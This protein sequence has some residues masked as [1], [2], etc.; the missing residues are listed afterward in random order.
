MLSLFIFY[1]F[2]LITVKAEEEP[3]PKWACLNSKRCDL[4]DANCSANFVGN[5]HTARLTVNDNPALR[6]A[7]SRP[8][9]ILECFN[10]DGSQVCTTGDSARDLNFKLCTVD[11][12]TS[13]CKEDNKT[14]LV[15]RYEYEFQNL[16]DGNGQTVQMPLM[17]TADGNFA[18]GALEWQDYTP[19]NELR[20]FYSLNFITQGVVD[21]GSLGGVQQSL[22]EFITT[23]GDCDGIAWDPYGVVFDSATLEPVSSPTKVEL[24]K[25]RDNGSFTRVLKDEVFAG[26]ITNPQLLQED[27]IFNFNVKDGTYQLQLLGSTIVGGLTVEEVIA[28]LHPNYAKIYSD[29]YVRDEPIVQQG[30][31]E[32]RD[33]PVVAGSGTIAALKLMPKDYS[34]QVIPQAS[35]ILI[36]NARVS[37]PYAR[38]KPYSVIP[39]GQGGFRRYRLLKDEQKGDVVFADE[40]GR[41]DLIM[42]MADFDSAGGEQWG[43]IVVEK[44]DLTKTLPPLAPTA[45]P[46]PRDVVPPVDPESPGGTSFNQFKNS[47]LSLVRRLFPLPRDVYAQVQSSVTKF[48][49]I[50]VY[51]EG[52]A[53]DAAG[54]IIPNAKVSLYLKYWGKPAFETTADEKGYFKIT[55]E[56]MPSTT[57]SIKYTSPAGQTA[58]V[59][60]SKFIT[61]NKDYIAENKVQLYTYQNKAGK[62]PYAA[63]A[64]QPY[65]FVSPKVSGQPVPAVG[66]QTDVNKTLVSSLT[67]KVSNPMILAG[68]IL[69]LLLGTGGIML[70]I[71]LYK[72]NTA[73]P[74]EQGAPLE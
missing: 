30:A 63:L 45:T 11:E 42:S 73:P 28:K 16:F 21:T 35:R 32:H 7:S 66:D 71:F 1:L 55:S 13:Q 72:K 6:P 58:T 46:I 37:H 20:S 3:A 12:D 29:I 62:N 27:G 43:E 26:L 23:Q 9:Y 22:L 51:L 8:T 57:F 70:G 50:P 34:Y 33:I 36:K 10:I 52:Y 47:I 40:K 5:A 68:V 17:T 39:D 15:K 41:F 2:P 25:K 56:N 19:G 49:P 14:T 24:M 44:T 69:L 64:K 4:A 54:K 48:E 61:Q 31:A 38:I 18:T 60:T 74:P 67:E 59:S 65:P 53:Y